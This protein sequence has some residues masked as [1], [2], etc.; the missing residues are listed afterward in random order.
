[1]PA[2]YSFARMFSVAALVGL[3]SVPLAGCAMNPKP[4]MDQDETAI[5]DPLEPVNRVTFAFNEMLDAVLF[6]PLTSI[7]HNVVP[8]VARNAVHN[9][10]DNLKSP[11]YMA[12]ELLQGNVKDAGVVARRFATNTVLGIGG[13]VD[14]AAKQGV[15]YQPED[16]GQTLATWGV[17]SGPYIVWPILGPSSLRDS[18]GFAADIAMDPL[19]WYAQNTDRDGINQGRAAATFIDTKD[20]TLDVMQDL[21]RNSGDMYKAL[22][23]VYVQRR[24]ALVNDLEPGKQSLP[25]IE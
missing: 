10:V 2:K 8:E 16:F 5:S 11:V 15:K 1:M 23:S 17:D 20:R 14:V 6:T 4:G 3:L 7:Y 12:N 21:R 18:V 22:Q 25:E 9:V 13:I 19:Y 24:K